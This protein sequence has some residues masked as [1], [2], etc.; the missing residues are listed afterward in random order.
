MLASKLGRQGAGCRSW[1]D[2]LGTQRDPDPAAGRRSGP[3]RDPNRV[4]EPR[5]GYPCDARR[6]AQCRDE[7][8]PFRGQ[9]LPVLGDLP[10]PHTTQ[11]RDDQLDSRARTDRPH[12]QPIALPC[13]PAA[14]RGRA[15]GQQVLPRAHR[16]RLTRR[17]TRTPGSGLPRTDPSGRNRPVDPLPPGR[18]PIHCTPATS[19]PPTND[20][21]CSG[22]RDALPRRAVLTCRSWRPD[23]PQM[24]TRPTRRE[25]HRDRR[26]QPSQPEYPIPPHPARTALPPHAAEA[27]APPAARPGAARGR[28]RSRPNGRHLCRT[29]IR[30]RDRTRRP[31]N[32]LAS[33]RG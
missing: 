30:N 28:H 6:T 24:A 23:R 12:R 4:R 15:H 13:P 7:P 2:L 9:D 20:P 8:A 18:T 27:P 25:R 21:R 3:R 17:D 22:P 10:Q 1:R 11:R 19:R 5:L 29:W 31:S 33:D 14:R 32:W 16:C 26:R